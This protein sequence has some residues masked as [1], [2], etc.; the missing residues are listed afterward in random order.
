[1]SDGY[2]RRVDTEFKAVGVGLAISSKCVQCQ[3]KTGNHRKWGKAKRGPLRGLSGH[4]CAECQ[5]ENLPALEK[6]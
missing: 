2:G 3:R 5:R 4:L 6:A 1:M